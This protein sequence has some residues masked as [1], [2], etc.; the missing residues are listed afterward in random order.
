MTV[1]FICVLISDSNYRCEQVTSSG[2]LVL[3]GVQLVIKMMSYP[4]L[5]LGYLVTYIGKTLHTQA[6]AQTCTRALT[7]THTQ[8]RGDVGRMWA[9]NDVEFLF[10]VRRIRTNGVQLYLTRLVTPSEWASVCVC[11][12]VCEACSHPPRIWLNYSGRNLSLKAVSRHALCE[13]TSSPDLE[14]SSH[15]GKCYFFKRHT[16]S[17]IRT[18]IRV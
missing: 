1:K 11:T 13:I 2:L 3:N 17:N 15:D 4:E 7:H 14:C 18:Y 16:N 9:Y 6:H 8:E 12:F 5:N 10:L